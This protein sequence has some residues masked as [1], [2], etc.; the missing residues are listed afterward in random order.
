MDALGQGFQHD[1]F[2]RGTE[3]HNREDIAE[4]KAFGEE[5]DVAKS[6]IAQSFGVRTQ[7]SSNR[8]AG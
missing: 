3:E 6:D 1:A 7:E 2:Q 4:G 5:M 8:R